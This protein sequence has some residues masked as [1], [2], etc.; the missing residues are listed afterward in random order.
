MKNFIITINYIKTCL[1]NLKLKKLVFRD[2]AL[3]VSRNCYGAL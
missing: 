2:I 3:V 1:K